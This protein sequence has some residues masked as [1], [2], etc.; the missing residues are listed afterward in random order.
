VAAREQG[1]W[2]LR[3]VA[4]GKL[5]HQERVDR[6][7]DAW[8]QV[9]VDLSSFAGRSVTLRLEQRALAGPS[10]GYWRDLWVQLGQETAQ[11]R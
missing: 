3:V 4:E 7:G 5:L 11:A 10:F 9:K 2:E 6:R 1:D 8:K